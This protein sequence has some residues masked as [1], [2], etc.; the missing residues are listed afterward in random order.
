MPATRARSRKKTCNLFKRTI[1]NALAR[2]EQLTVSEWAEKYRVLDESS[3]LPGRWS[4]SI[5]PYLAGIMDCFNDPYIQ[6][7]NFV[8]STQVGGTEAII[9]ALGWII[10]QNPSPTMLVYPTD[11]LA[12]DISN[13]KLKPALTKMPEI[14][15]RYFRTKSSEMNMRFKGMNVYLRSGGSPSKLASKAIKYLFFD[16]I[17]KM[18]GAAKNEASPYNL[19]LERTKTFR[20][21]RKI[22]TCSTPTH[23]ENYVWK[24]HEQADAQM[25][26]YVPCPH[27]GE[28]IRLEW[29]QIKFD[30]ND[31]GKMT[32]AER[33]STAMYF[34]QECGAAID[35]REKINIIRRGEWRDE[36]KTYV[37]KPKRVSFHINA[38]Y[39][40][41]V[42]W[43]DIVQEFLDTKSDPE[44][45]Q[46]F[47]N[48]WIAEPWEDTKLKT[49][50]DLVMDRRAPEGEGVVPDWAQM[51]TAGA[52]VQE[53]SVYFDIIAWGPSLTS[54]SIYH[55]QVLSLEDLD[56][57]MNAEYKNSKNEAF[58][59]QLCLVD[60]GNDTDNVYQ[61]CLFREWAEA[62][63]GTDTMNNHYRI[64]TINKPDKNYHGQRLV[65]VD[66]GKYKDTIATRLHYKNGMGACMVH[67]DCD[68]EYAK[69]LTA[70][71]KVAEGTGRRR[72][73]IWKPKTSHADNHYL[74]SRVYASAAADCLNV[75]TLTD[76]KP[77]T[78]APEPPKPKENKSS[79]INGY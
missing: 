63:K 31:D 59:V 76:E 60:S 45:L 64:S 62:A 37:G 56:P 32:N 35:D 48:S 34:C 74:D 77:L 79:W 66:G 58:F 36:K 46:N 43:T 26:Y 3:A 67:S 9:N 10:T 38:L 24:I 2:P 27:C 14:A 57:V 72:R 61:F 30:A 49:S 25:Y 13:D 65:L 33:A 4:N 39:S 15:S 11:D 73:L 12:K 28:Y 78:S 42:S 53:N 75:R 51:L 20:Y 6:H 5:T 44:A 68:V 69:Q 54:Q 71:H 50:V 70:E 29:E 55:G 47:I 41:F 18:G 1:H 19:A 52:D 8:K 22:Y 23:R 40:F 16:E 17:D 7:I 21:T